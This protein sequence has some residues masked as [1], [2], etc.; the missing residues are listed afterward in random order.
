MVLFGIL[1]LLLGEVT[2]L[3]EQLTVLQHW[4]HRVRSVRLSGLPQHMYLRSLARIEDRTI[5][6]SEIGLPRDR[7]GYLD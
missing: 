1:E 4:H 3:L 2:L 6:H 5:A 7:H